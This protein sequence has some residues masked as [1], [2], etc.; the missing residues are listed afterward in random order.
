M[1]DLDT[2]DLKAHDKDFLSTIQLPVALDP[3]A[4]CPRWIRF[5]DE[6]LEA[7]TECIAILQEFVGLCLVPDTS[8]QKALILVGE[9]ANG[10]S[11]L[12]QVVEELLGRQNVCNVAL[13]DLH[14][15]FHRARLVGKLVNISTEINPK[16]LEKSDYFKSIV[17]GDSIS[18][19]HKH[20]PVFDF[21]P[22]CRLIFACNRLPR[23]RDTSYGFHRR[24]IIVPF[25][26][27]F[28]GNKAD[29]HLAS[30]L[31]NELDGIFQWAL[32]GLTRLR[33]QGHFT[34]SEATDSALAEYRRLNN[35]LIAFTE[36]KCQ[37]VKGIYTQK[38]DLYEAYK[39]YI[40]K[41]GYQPLNQGN[42]FKELYAIYPQLKAVRPRT[43]AGRENVVEGIQVVRSV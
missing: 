11:V 28:E 6:V 27:K 13:G 16:T 9:G 37:I 38:D 24:L 33:D 39:K 42:F 1:L 41:H 20:K 26:R 25:N 22:V 2:F 7:D 15:E 40:E 14:N 30:R 12:L 21:R 4:T 43:D 23:V 35:P 8:Y 19:S 10:K 32:R 29:L 5:L 17:T 3:N 31:L 36:D 34:G 18:A